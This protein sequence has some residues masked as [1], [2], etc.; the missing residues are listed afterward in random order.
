M[1]KDIED[2]R[3]IRAEAKDYEAKEIKLSSTD[4]LSRSTKQPWVVPITLEPLATNVEVNFE[5][6]P[7]HA[8]ITI[9]GGESY[10][11]PVKVP[12]RFTR[13]SSGS[14]WSVVKVAC[15]LA[16][17]ADET[18]SL[19]YDTL[20]GGSPVVRFKLDALA[21]TVEVNFTSDPAGAKITVEGGRS[22]TTPVK[23]PI[24][25]A[26]QA[27]SASWPP[28]KITCTLADYA[29]ETR[30][31]TY[32]NL[33]GANPTEHISLTQIRRAL[34]VD[35]TA[36]VDAATVTVDGRE[37]G[38]TPL[39]RTFIFTRAGGTDP[40]NTFQVVVA[41]ANY[42]Y[43]PPGVKL[44]P[45]EAPSFSTSLRIEDALTGKLAVSL[46]QVQ[47]VVSPVYELVP[48]PEGF[49]IVQKN[50]LSQIGEAE[51]EPKVGVATRMSDFELDHAKY[52]TRIGVRTNSQQMLI[53]IAFWPSES[54]TN[55]VYFNLWMQ[56]GNEQTRLTDGQFQDF[57]PTVTSDDQWIYFASNRL[58]PA[59][60]SIWRMRCVGKG[61]LTKIT[62]SPSSLFDTEPSVSPDGKKLAYTSLLRG[63]RERQIWIASADGTLPTQIRVGRSPCWSPDG[64]RMLYVAPD[65]A[66]R[67][68]IWVM[69][70]DGGNPTQLT[71]GDHIDEY[72]SWTP[73]AKRIVY[74]S[75]Q[76]INGEGE[77][78]F[79]IWVM[80]ADGTR[81]TQL[82]VNGSHDT[83]PLMTPDGKHVLF[84]SNRGA[85]RPGEPALQIWRIDLPAE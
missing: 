68:K 39:R 13:S 29:D 51:S 71:S 6:A 62:D 20:A 56:R 32:D 48:G 58:L 61:G 17:Y 65:T 12:I 73:D 64:N 81:N 74:A 53:S 50:I 78:N 54:E 59:S 37:I 36:N 77:P 1:K 27:A 16:N 26:R 22:Y 31:L 34:P 70:A 5:S 67:D 21:A 25:F 11:A 55:K 85:R 43:R 63:A 82:T 80:N 30:L 24:P 3:V 40:W 7:S 15:S 23:V 52:E 38:P 72:P 42:R 69:E 35:I 2:N 45:G 41:K 49:R 10:T 79:D 66:G 83:R 84:N 9:E 19:N 4:A 46:E 44:P 28:V 76:A 60:S 75:N 33:A 47:Y 18:R 8:K 57:D 14:P